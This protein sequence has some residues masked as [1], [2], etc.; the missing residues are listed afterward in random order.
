MKT[1]LHDQQNVVVLG[2]TFSRQLDS[3]KK[4]NPCW[5]KTS[6]NRNTGSCHGSVANDTD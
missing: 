5:N 1:N 6:I 3:L 4:P 2:Q